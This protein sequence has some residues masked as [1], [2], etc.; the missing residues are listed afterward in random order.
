VYAQAP[1]ALMIYHFSSVE[2]KVNVMG[3][4]FTGDES[5]VFAGVFSTEIVI[6]KNSP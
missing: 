6:P 2:T 4:S 3:F 5:Q 1:L